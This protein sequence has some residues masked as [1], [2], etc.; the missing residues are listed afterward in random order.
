MDSGLL[1]QGEIIDD[2]FDVQQDLSIEQVIGVMDQLLA[3]EV[4]RCCFVVAFPI[5]K[6]RN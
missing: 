5:F 4:R 2:G 3:F 1:L 6:S